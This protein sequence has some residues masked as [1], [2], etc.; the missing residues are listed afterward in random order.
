MSDSNNY[1]NDSDS[2]FEYNELDLD[3]ELI[4][5]P[6]MFEIQDDN[7]ETMRMTVQKT[8]LDAL[9]PKPEAEL[10]KG[11]E[12]ID[13]FVRNFLIRTGLTTTLQTFQNEFYEK[14]QSGTINKST[15]ESPPDVYFENQRLVKEVQRLEVLV[16]QYREETSKAMTDYE[17]FRKERDFLKNHFRRVKQNNKKLQQDMKLLKKHYDEYPQTVAKL[18]EKYIKASKEKALANMEISKLKTKLH[19]AYETIK[20]LE[21]ANEPD[22]IKEEVKTKPKEPKAVMNV[23]IPQNPYE[24]VAFPSLPSQMRQKSQFNVSERAASCLAL[25]PVKPFLAVGGDDC[26]FRLFSVPENNAVA[27]FLGHDDWLSSVAFSNNGNTMATGSG[28]CT[29]SL[30]DLRK[31]SRSVVLRGHT[32][33]V[34][35]VSFHYSDDFVVSA[36]MDQTA[37]IWDIIRNV[38]VTSLRG[39]VD[40]VNSC[41]FQPYTNYVITA[42][43]DETVSLWDA[44]TSLCTHTLVG[45]EAPIN[46][47]RFSLT[48]YLAASCDSDGMAIVWD[49]RTL[50]V[51]HQFNLGPVSANSLT[52]H[53]K[54]ES[55]A[56]GSDDSCVHICPFG[57][58]PYTLEGHSD[59]VQSVLFAK[60]PVDTCLYSCSTDGSVFVWCS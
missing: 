15:L 26:S 23:E 8:Q 4:D 5:D 2:D 19:S 45:H 22:E 36:S 16:K 35:D 51:L 21:K 29:V 43:A 40:S 12:A 52:W 55:I 24:N 48:N 59:T 58:T 37:K 54:S 6:E 53:P 10:Q 50:K 56:V 20:T 11:S 47:A 32:A 17:K 42:S 28:D 14:L 39:H 1:I 25:H 60:D 33:P 7:F 41:E 9:P 38:N 30:W 13:D 34:W 27:S 44:R 18:E 3:E 31:A 46:C 57:E 49:L